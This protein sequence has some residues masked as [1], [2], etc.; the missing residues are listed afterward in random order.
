MT[1][2]RDGE[3]EVRRQIMRRAA[4]YTAGFAAAAVAIAAVGAA[5]IA[6][7][8]TGRGLPFGRTWLTVM[9]I[10]ILPGL[11]AAIWKTIRAR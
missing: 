9:G 5:L 7:M 1:R 4:M 6:W 8:L 10:V 3:A 11:L 2:P